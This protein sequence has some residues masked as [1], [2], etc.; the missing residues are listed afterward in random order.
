MREI[1]PNQRWRCVPLAAP[2]T[3]LNFMNWLNSQ[4]GYA[5]ALAHADDGVIWGFFQNG[6]WAWS[7]GVAPNSPAIHP[8]NVLQ[9]RLFGAQ[10]ETML[11]R[12]GAGFAGRIIEDGVGESIDWLD[13][14][15]MLWGQPDGAPVGGFQLMREGSQGLVHAPPAA[16]A[17]AKKMMT[18]NYVSY[19]ADGRAFVKASRLVA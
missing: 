10:G 13:E 3:I 8:Q 16:I 11:W 19:D 1:T 18:R 15:H 9:I 2:P 4:T 6:A 5:Y 12:E 17:S 7:G 14:A